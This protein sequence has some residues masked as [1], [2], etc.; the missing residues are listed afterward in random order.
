MLHLDDS[1]EVMRVS[2]NNR[3]AGT[4]GASHENFQEYYE[5]WRIFDQ[6]CNSEELLLKVQLAPGDCAVFM[7]GRVM[8]GRE[9]YTPGGNRHIQG[10]YVD[11]DAV[12]STANWAI[13]HQT[14]LPG[15]VHREATLAVL[16]AL[17]SQSQ[18]SYGEGID[19]LQHALQAAHCAVEERESEQ[20]VLA[21]LLHDIGN[22]VPARQVWVSSG[23]PEPK[24]L[25][26]R[27][28]GSIGYEL[29]DSIGRCYLEHVG[30]SAM[31]AGAVGLHV[32]AKR[33][34]VGM[35]RSYV[36]QLSAASIETL[37]FQGG[38]MSP[39]ELDRFHAAP[40]SQIALRLR[41]Y[42]DR[43]KHVDLVV[44]DAGSYAELIYNHLVGCA[45]AGEMSHRSKE[46][47]VT[48]SKL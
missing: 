46:D 40:G 7:N 14:E 1:G 36:N 24:L 41:T 31:V 15:D 27:S 6:I 2:F 26:S 44:P 9:E 13:A 3:S 48:Q 12:K 39:S 22:T 20:A 34:L 11:H 47:H 35:D 25:V 10:C 4:L 43:G 8:H 16:Q 42:D 23:Q 32:N 45:S 17:Q 19:M 28:D 5:A 38:A 21:A 33:A 37:G 30:F 29:H 18:F